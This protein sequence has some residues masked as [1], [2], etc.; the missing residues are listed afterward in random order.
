[1]A[2]AAVVASAQPRGKPLAITLSGEPPV[3]RVENSAIL[4]RLNNPNYAVIFQVTVDQPG[5][6]PL[7][8]TYSMMAGTLAFAPKYPLQPGLSYRATFRLVNEAAAVSLTLPKPVVTASTSVEHVYPSTAVLPENQLKFYIHFSAPMSRG[9]AF[10]RIHLLEDGGGEVKLPFLEIDEE[11]WDKEQRRLTVLF[12][13][14]RVK[15][16]LVPNEEVGP[17]LQAGRKY[18]LVIDA[19]WKDSTNA[20]LVKA[21]RKGFSVAAAERT[22]IDPQTW[23]LAPPRP[24]TNDPLV[25]DFPRPLD[26]ALLQRFL[27]VIGPAG[28]AIPGQIVLDRDET[29]WSFTPASPWAAG[30]HT[31][32]ILT[33]LEDL[34]GNKIGRAFDVDRFEQVQARNVS[35]VY[36]L[37]FTVSTTPGAP[38]APKQK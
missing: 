5:A 21:F 20:P 28:K 30:G 7:A 17:P 35:E 11:L 25:L 32:E 22:P 33:S 27:D 34:A 31:I 10:R 12:D 3:F 8:G 13:P 16:G 37:R 1:V 23:R 9:E 36:T 24:A 26:A 14:G 29:R 38:S 15:R 4:P 19:E 18:T 2:L 6:P